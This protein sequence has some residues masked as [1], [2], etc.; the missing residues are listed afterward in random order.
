[1]GGSGCCVSNCCVANRIKSFF[2]NLFGKSKGS[3]SG[4]S[5]SSYDSNVADLE[6][7]VKVQ[8]AL[9]EFREDTREKSERLENDIIKESRGA[10][11][12][13]I[14]EIKKYNKIRYGGSMLNINISQLE[15]E[16]RKTEDQI[17]GFI[18]NRVSKR[19]SLDDAECLEILKLDPGAEKTKRLDNFYK[20]VLKEAIRELTDILRN[21]MEKQT[22]IAED[23][24]Q[25]RIDSILYT[26]QNK[27]EEFQKIENV[28]KSGQAKMEEEQIRLAH[29][30]SLCELGLGQ[31]EQ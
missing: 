16:N 15:R 12:E 3:S 31:L 17:H 27:T 10:L 29:M 11:D 28:K 1:M 2:R 8:N 6:L 26:V 7:T 20:K 23:Y 9:T 22:D 13:F 24:I 4:G 30:I 21:A 18:V 25:R 19:I 14:R 5:T